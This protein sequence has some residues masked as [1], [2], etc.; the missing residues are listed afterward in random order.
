MAKTKSANWVEI[1]PER[2][3][4][5]KTETPAAE[6]PESPAPASE[7][8]ANAKT[9]TQGETHAGETKKKT[10]SSIVETWAAE[11]KVSA[12]VDKEAKRRASLT[13]ALSGAESLISVLDTLPEA[14]RTPQV[15]ALLDVQLGRATSLRKAIGALQS[16]ERATITP[17][18]A[19]DLSVAVLAHAWGV[20]PSLI[21]VE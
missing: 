18:Q 13:E 1:T 5:T 8:P 19:A 7:T 11:A 9:E 16:V 15:K 21:S 20:H 10:L 12:P 2:A 14:A 6:A 17:K 4:E 3:S